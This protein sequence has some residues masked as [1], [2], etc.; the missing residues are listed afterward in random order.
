MIIE[1][2]KTMSNIGLLLTDILKPY[3]K[4]V[5]FTIKYLNDTEFP[6]L[7]VFVRHG[8]LQDI[9]QNVFVEEVTKS[10]VVNNIYTIEDGKLYSILLRPLREI[11][12]FKI[13]RLQNKITNETYN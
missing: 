10:D 1:H 6:V 12:S 3:T 4:E 5:D 8:Q 9:D 13:N 7:E 11:R 2:E